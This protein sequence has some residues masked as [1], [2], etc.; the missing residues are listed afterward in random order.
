MAPQVGDELHARIEV[1]ANR[2]ATS[3]ARLDTTRVESSAAGVR[4]E[5]APRPTAELEALQAKLRAAESSASLQAA[6]SS[7]LE[8]RVAELEAALVGA[9]DQRARAEAQAE[10]AR[11]EADRALDQLE[12]QKSERSGSSAP[13]DPTFTEAFQ[14]KLLEI[15]RLVSE[16]NALRRSS[17]EWRTKARTL[18]RER[19]DSTLAL[20]RT[21]SQLQD[22]REREAAA[23]RKLAELE[24]LVG[25]Q[26]KELEMAERRAKHLRQHIGGAAR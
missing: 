9:R 6:R 5:P 13:I 24:K 8:D 4:V 19:D 7:A 22:L 21:E 1:L 11:A 2:I 26:Q 15:D 20:A 10:S 25:E 23:K 17:D 18:T 16:R 12:R 3:H 14:A